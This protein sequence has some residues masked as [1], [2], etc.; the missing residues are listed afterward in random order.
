MANGWSGRGPEPAR[1]RA[2]HRSG[3][4]LAAVHH[5][6]LSGDPAGQIR[7][8]EQGHVGHF[9]RGAE[10][11]ERNAA[12]NPLI[13]IRIVLAGLIP[14]PAGKLDGPGARPLTRTPWVA[15]DTARLPV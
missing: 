11:P 4:H 9:L 1:R 12:A 3:E 7:G 6:G 13:E 5:Q 15:I 2:D 14:D 10:A 8:Q